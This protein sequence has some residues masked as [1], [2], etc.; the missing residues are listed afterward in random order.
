[1]FQRVSQE[2]LLMGGPLAFHQH[3]ADE[4]LAGSG[5]VHAV[6]ADGAEYAHQLVVEVVFVQIEFFVE[7]A[8]EKFGNAK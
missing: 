6:V 2:E 8:A 1:M 5:A 7:M 3:A 4:Q